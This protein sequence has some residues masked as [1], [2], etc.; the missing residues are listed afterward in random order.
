MLALS[1]PVKCHYDEILDFHI[2]YFRTRYVVFPRYLGKSQSITNIRL[3]VFL[4]LYSRSFTAAI[5]AS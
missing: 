3:K 5:R 4:D 1:N 2:L